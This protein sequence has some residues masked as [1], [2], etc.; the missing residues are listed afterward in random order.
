MSCVTDLQRAQHMFHLGRLTAD[1]PPQ[2]GT[3]LKSP[4]LTVQVSVQGQQVRSVR[5]A[6]G[7]VVH[8]VRQR[9]RHPGHRGPRRIPAQGRLLFVSRPAVLKPNLRRGSTRDGERAALDDHHNTTVDMRGWRCCLSRWIS[10]VGGFHPSDWW[11]AS[12]FYWLFF[13]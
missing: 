4:G 2:R 8:V 7:R 11:G 10:L 3:D 9:R 12:W 1:V 5:A 13:L 6:E